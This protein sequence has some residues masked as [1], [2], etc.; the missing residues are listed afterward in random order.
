MLAVLKVECRPGF[1]NVVRMAPTDFEVLLQ[2]AG[3]RI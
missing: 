2:I 3:D 1:K